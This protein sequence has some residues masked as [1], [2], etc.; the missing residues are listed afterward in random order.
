[1]LGVVKT[2]LLGSE[3]V[4]LGMIKGSTY[5]LRIWPD[6]SM[7]YETHCLQACCRLRNGAL[8]VSHLS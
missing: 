5:N 1:M 8:L 6:R 4:S 3:M 2:G 7:A